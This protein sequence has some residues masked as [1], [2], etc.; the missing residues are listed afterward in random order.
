MEAN[1]Q[2]RRI[3]MI[4]PEPFFEPRGTPFSVL[5]RLKALSLLGHEVDLLTYP[6]GQDVGIPGVRIIRTTPIRFVRRVPIGPSWTKL[7]LDIFLLAKAVRLLLNSRYDLLHTHEEACV[8][9]MVL[10][11]LF[12]TRHLYDMHSSLPQQLENCQFTRFRPLIALFGWME[13]Q[14]IRSSDAVISICPALDEHLKQLNGHGRH[15]MIENVASVRDSRAVTTEELQGFMT[16]HSFLVNK[17]IV[18]YTGTFEPYQGIDLL[19]A[20]AEQVL[21]FHTDVLFLLVGGNPD[22]VQYYKERVSQLGLSKYFHFTGSRPPE[23]IPIFV[24]VSQVLVSPRTTGTNTP[25]KIYSY[26]ESGKPIV[27]TRLPTHT[28][29]LNPDVAVLVEPDPVAFAQGLLI[30]FENPLLGRKLGEEARK[31]FE[32]RYSFEKFVY[33][34]DRALQLALS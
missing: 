16:A 33:K 4:A 28:Q 14:V 11:N 8:F 32:D 6:I 15:V 24:K 9:G 2:R 1:L 22:Q 29:V 34:T 10:A 21:R 26:L 3:L 23:E 30:L 25:L 12:G 17:K 13:H 5:G 18:L 31:L 20:S 7:F 19:I 27:A